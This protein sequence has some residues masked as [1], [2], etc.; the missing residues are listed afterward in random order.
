VN[1][2]SRRVLEKAGL[3]LV[4]TIHQPC[5]D[6]IA[7]SEAGDVEYALRKAEWEQPFPGMAA[8]SLHTTLIYRTPQGRRLPACAIRA[9]RGLAGAG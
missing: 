9:I 1:I 7:G 2:A 3:K 4:R 5:Q 8:P 6:P